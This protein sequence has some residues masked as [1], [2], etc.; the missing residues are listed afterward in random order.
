MTL[1]NAITLTELGLRYTQSEGQTHSLRNLDVR[2]L[3]RMY[4]LLS[5]RTT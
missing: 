1:P 2:L 5:R 3:P 4:D